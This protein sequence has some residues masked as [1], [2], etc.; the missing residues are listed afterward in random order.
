MKINIVNC[1][2]VL[3]SVK[4][5]NIR[6]NDI[7]K[8]KVLVDENNNLPEI[9]YESGNIKDKSKNF[10][11]KL[12][13]S[14]S[15]HLEQVYTLEGK[16]SI[17]IVYLGITNIENIH[18]LDKKYKLVDFSIKDNKEIILDNEIF[19]YK[20]I[21]KIDGNNIEYTHEID[22]KDSIKNK[23]LLE[24][25]IS[26]KRIRSNIDNTDIMFKFM[27]N[28]FTLEDVRIVYELIKNTTVDK[29]NFRKKIIKYVEETNN[30]S[31]EKNGYRP[32]KKYRFK[33]LK[34]DAWV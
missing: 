26:Y 20:T 2:F 16:S 33:P 21:E 8:I 25:L 11:F 19:K 10:I 22:V 17:D 27:A 9:E 7:K 24:L 18:S 32:S 1:I 12:I 29:S 14:D 13:G 5:D 4:N 30:S 23:N 6:K 15:Y 3:D 28:T 31:E 34:G